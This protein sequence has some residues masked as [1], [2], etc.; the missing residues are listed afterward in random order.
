MT[1]KPADEARGDRLAEERSRAQRDIQE[2]AARKLQAPGCP[3]RVLNGNFLAP[4]FREQQLFAG[5]G[6][7]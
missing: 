5:T 7:D 1:E 3:G 2:E 6:R 4:W